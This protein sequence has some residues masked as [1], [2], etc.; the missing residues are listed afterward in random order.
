MLQQDFY[1]RAIKYLVQ[2]GMG[3]HTVHTASSYRLNLYHKYYNAHDDQSAKEAWMKSLQKIHV[4]EKPLMLGI[5]SDTGG[6][7]QR[8]ANWGPLFIRHQIATT[9]YGDFNDLGDIKVIPHLLHDK[10]LNEKTIKQCQISL[11]QTHEQDLPVS[12]LSIADDLCQKLWH[13]HPTAKLIMLGGDHSV[14]YPVVINWLKSRKKQKKRTAILHF[15]AHTDLSVERLGIDLCFGTWAYHILEHLTKPSDLIQFGIRSSQKEKEHWEKTLGVKQ[16]WP[17]DF[18]N[19]GLEKII[20]FTKEYLINEKVEEVY[21][22][23]DIDALSSEYAP[24]TGTP[25]DGGLSPH[26][27]VAIIAGIK[28]CC[29]I[30]S[31]DLVEVAPFVNTNPEKNNAAE[32]TL[33]S[34]K[35]I[36][37]KFIEVLKT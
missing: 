2:P 22:S 5:C 25:E 32:V 12:P 29:S 27:I 13:Y 6:G 15:D 28:D 33:M 23:C 8:G 24:A 11:Y 37:Q 16:F 18:K 36:L 9:S 21:I 19:G 3:V 17:D 30:T 7:I 14:S 20:Q 26:E 35:I 34:A 1:S 4:E 10:Y 31:V